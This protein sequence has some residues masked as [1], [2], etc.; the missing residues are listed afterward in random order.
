MENINTNGDSKIRKVLFNEITLLIALAG[1]VSSVILWVIN[2]Q[3]DL[4]KQII[5][6]KAQVENN[7]TVTAALEK[8]KANDLHEIQIRLD[9][10][11]TR[12]IAQLEAIARIEA[13]LK[14]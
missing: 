6:L 1:V 3:R 4:E 13:L 12:Q 2:P 10:I 14:K 11:E 8:I 5:M 7:Q 9:K